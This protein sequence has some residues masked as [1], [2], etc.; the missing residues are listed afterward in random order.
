MLVGMRIAQAP[1]CKRL[2]VPVF[3]DEFGPPPIPNFVDSWVLGLKS[4]WVGFGS[5]KLLTSPCFLLY[6]SVISFRSY[7]HKSFCPFSTPPTSFVHS[8]HNPTSR[9]AFCRRAQRTPLR[10]SQVKHWQLC[11]TNRAVRQKHWR[12]ASE[13]GK[14]K[15]DWFKVSSRA[16]P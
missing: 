4:F 5:L 2:H 3:S 7:P 10:P 1:N 12:Y 15:C 9:M 13:R 6:V 8:P 11:G 16:H 14:R